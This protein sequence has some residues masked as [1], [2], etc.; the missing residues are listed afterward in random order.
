MRGILS[1]TIAALLGLV[2]LGAAAAGDDE[3]GREEIER[4][5]QKRLAD[6]KAEDGWLSVTGLYWLRSGETRLGSDPA[7]DLLLSDRLPVS[8]GTLTLTAG[9]VEFRPAPGSSS[10]ATASRS[11]E[12]RFTRM[13]PSIP[14]RSPALT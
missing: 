10:P 7:N 2:S 9:K 6:L 13:R 3:S 8:V 4:W 12:G 11:R 5:R 14:T 1:M